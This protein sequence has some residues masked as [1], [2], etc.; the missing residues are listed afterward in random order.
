MG[1]FGSIGKAFGGAAKFVGNQ[2]ASGAKKAVSATRKV[3]DFTLRNADK[4]GAVAGSV[5][6]GVG[7]AIG[8]AAGAAISNSYKA[9]DSAVQGRGSS[10]SGAPS[11]RGAPPTGITATATGF[12]SS[13]ST[14]LQAVQNFGATQ[15]TLIPGTSG[16]VRW[17]DGR[18][19]GGFSTP[20]G[21]VAFGRDASRTVN[22]ASDAPPSV[23]ES[24]AVLV[25]GALVAGVV[26]LKAL[27]R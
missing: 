21:D 20:W 4:I 9:I 5:V 22:R 27:E 25:G 11:F 12:G 18:A 16:G 8:G 15:N 13:P 10:G 23:L 26:L 3:N 17:G 2:V 1:I 6:P 14:G 24:P 19:T 7:T